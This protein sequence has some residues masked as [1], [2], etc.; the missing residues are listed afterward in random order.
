MNNFDTENQSVN[1]NNKNNL[2]NMTEKEIKEYIGF[3][4]FK[5]R[6]L[7]IRL[8]KTLLATLA[9]AFI[10]CGVMLIITKLD[11]WDIS[12]WFSLL[13][14]FGA[15]AITFPCV[16]LPLS[17]TDKKLA[18]RLD[19]ELSLKERMHT[20]LQNL[21]NNSLMSVLLRQD[22]KKATEKIKAKR[23]KARG[24]PVY[25]AVAVIGLATL[26]TGLAIKQEKVEPPPPPPPPQDEAWSLS[27]EDELAIKEIIK[28]VEDSSMVSLAKEELV[29]KMNE[30]LTALKQEDN[31]EDARNLVA[32]CADE[33]D[34][35]TYKTGSSGALYDAIKA[36]N[37]PFTR[38]IARMLTK[39]DKTKYEIK[40]SDAIDSLKHKY[41]EFEEI[42]PEQQ[43]EM[44]E[45]TMLLL[46]F[47]SLDVLSALAESGV[48][49]SDTLYGYLESLI[50]INKNGVYGIKTIGEKME[51]FNY[52]WASIQL[53]GLKDTTL[54]NNI[55]EE[56]LSQN[57]NYSVG[58]GASDG[59]R[60]LFEIAVPQREDMTSEDAEED[61]D[62]GVEEDEDKNAAGGYGPG[63][64]LGT[65]ELIY[66]KE[67]GQTIITQE[68]YQKYKEI[69]NNHFANEDGTVPEEIK[70]YFDLLLKGYE[71][72]EKENG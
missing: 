54:K 28:A 13:F 3:A 71:E 15:G 61:D 32:D 16:F 50:T 67:N 56:L 48:D 1:E 8:L 72:G 36:K 65:D 18:Y 62:S 33:M 69:M 14:G 4:K 20:S 41:E 29:G 43:K 34:K 7:A 55:Y 25:I 5:K 26:I 30:L 38:E 31:Y 40:F 17:F 27:M 58:Y 12:P 64:I 57:Q 70:K 10:A 23:I 37:T 39:T 35:I 9:F 21:D 11:A 60:E 45:D 2:M 49:S 6:L 66:D 19:E 53:E 52:G 42:T 47:A 51:V 22:L 63:L 59:L 46:S 24:L 68:I 44:K